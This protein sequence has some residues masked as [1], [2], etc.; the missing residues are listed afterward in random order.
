[1]EANESVVNFGNCDLW[2]PFKDL[3]A[4]IDAALNKK[5]LEALPDLEAA[6]RKHKPNF[7]SLFKN[8]SKNAVS[9]EAVKKSSTEGIRVLGQTGLQILHQSLVDESL[10]ISD[11]VDLNELNA[12][13]LLV[14]GQLQQPHFP[15][16]TRGLVAVLLYYDGRRTLVSSL[17]ALINARRGRTWTYGLNSELTAMITRYTDQLKEENVVTKVIDLIKQIDLPNELHLLQKNRALGGPRYRK[18][19]VDLIQE[20]RQTLADIVF[21]WSCQGQLSNNET[22]YLL[23]YISK[24]SCSADGSLDNVTLTLLISLLNVIDVSVLQTCEDGDEVVQLLHVVADREIIPSLHKE[25]FASERNWQTPK[26][27]TIVQF[28]WAVMLRTLLQFPL[29]SLME[30]FNQFMEQ[31]EKTIDIAIEDNAFESLL[32]LVVAS[33]M[34]HHEEF[35]VKR[36]HTLIT[37]FIVLMPLKVKELRN[38]GDDAARI[39]LAHMQ[40]GIL[41]PPNLSHHLE[42]LM[43]LITHL[44]KDDPLNLELALDYWC[45]TEVPTDQSYSYRPPQR[46]VS[47]YKFIRQSGDMLPAPLFVPYVDMLAGLS[48]SKLCAHH[49]Y[50]L[51]KLNGKNSTGQCSIVSWDHIFASLNR[52]YTSLRVELPPAS[53]Q[54]TYRQHSAMRGITPEEV[55]G[56]ISALRL[57]ETVV[58]NDEMA[59]IS[60]CDVPQYMPLTVL[61]GVVGCSVPPELKAALLKTLSAFALSANIASNLWQSLESFQIIP[62]IKTTSVYQPSGIH[63]ELEEVEARNEEFPITRA[64][65]KLL[66]V[67]FDHPLPS[68]LGSGQRTPGFAPYLEYIIDLVFLRFS[69]RAYRR[70][71]EK[72]EIAKLCL[73][74]FVKLLQDNDIKSDIR[75][76]MLNDMSSSGMMPSVP[77]DYILMTQLLRESGLLRTIMYILD[78][79]SCILSSYM[80]TQGQKQLEMCTLLC[81]ILLQKALIHQPLFLQQVREGNNSIIVSNLDQ[82]LMGIN[83]RHGCADYLVIVAKFVG[84]NAF[85]PKHALAAVRILRHICSNN[86]VA[87]HLA[88]AFATDENESKTLLHGFVECLDTNVLEEI[89]ENKEEKDWSSANFYN[90]ICQELL[91]LLLTCLKHPTPNIAHFLLGFQP[92]HAMSEITLQDP[93]VLGSP[94]TCLHAVLSMLDRGIDLYNYPTCVNEF[95]HVAELAFQLIYV[96]SRNKDTSGPTLRYLRTT[97]DFLYHHLQFLPYKIKKNN[98]KTLACQSWLLKTVATELRVTAAH[99]QR[100]HVQRLLNILLNDSFRSTNGVDIAEAS[101]TPS[102]MFVSVVTSI[103]EPIRRKLMQ[104]LD[105]LEFIQNWPPPPEWEYFDMIEIE[106]LFKAN[107]L[108][109]KDGFSQINVKNIQKQLSEEL[110]SLQGISAV[111]QR[112]VISQEVQSIIHYAKL[113]NNVKEKK[114]IKSQAF[115]AWHLVTEIVLTVCPLDML[116]LEQKHQVILEIAQ[117]LLQRILIDDTL[118]EITASASG[119]MLMLMTTLHHNLNPNIVAAETSSVQVSQMD[120]SNISLPTPAQYTALVI[121]LKRITEC[122]LRTGGGNQRVRINY[123]G[124]LLN[125]LGTVNHSSNTNLMRTQGEVEVLG[126]ESESEKMSREYTEAILEFGE[127]IMEIVCRDACSGH[128]ITKM[129]ALS[130]LDMAIFLDHQ[131]R[132]LNFLIS[133]GYLRHFIDSLLKDDKELQNILTKGSNSL[134]S[135]YVFESKLSLFT[136]IGNSPI[137]AQALLRNG[138]MERLTEC[139][140]L[141]LRPEIYRDFHLKENIEKNTWLLPN[142]FQCYQQIIIPALRVILSMMTSTSPKHLQ[143][144]QQL[145]NFILAHSGIFSDILRDRS[146]LKRLDSLAELSL[147]TAVLSRATLNESSEVPDVTHIETR[148]QI[149]LLRHQLLALLPVLI[150]HNWDSYQF[151]VLLD[152]SVDNVML[153]VKI[154]ELVS[155]VLS[156]CRMVV[157]SSGHGIMSRIL[158]TPN[159]SESLNSEKSH[160][161]DTHMQSVPTS[162]HPPGIGML[163]LLLRQCT[164]QLQVAVNAQKNFQQRIEGLPNL[165]FE[166]MSENLPSGIKTNPFVPHRKEMVYQTLNKLIFLYSQMANILRYIIEVSVYLLWHHLHFFLQTYMGEDLIYSKQ[167]TQ[168]KAIRKLQ[169]VQES[170]KEIPSYI[171]PKSQVTEDWLTQSDVKHLKADIS[172]VMNDYFF[173]ELQ[174]IEQYF[175]EDSK[176]IGFFEA[177]VCRLKRLVQQCT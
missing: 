131:H 153:K 43:Q 105:K 123:Y 1:M 115:E 61:L 107:E 155:N 22:L 37:D 52:Y 19:V 118:P 135:V 177:L 95:P 64:M 4:V 121:I 142:L 165:G 138:I 27:K 50:M 114:Y 72:W 73:Q 151:V 25:L 109:K 80:T 96:L 78:E 13:E 163:I 141:D 8:P 132:W 28:A 93:G 60:L 146:A 175:Q 157:A 33:S 51:L 23:D 69:T 38:R 63:I 89:D 66:N 143:G 158:F 106:R 83:P 108:D 42:H 162:R 48:G 24:Q 77:L 174:S 112:S 98:I 100:S 53:N 56:L 117:E 140:C 103:S 47:L 126:Q 169:A 35:F 84:Y 137:G 149:A 3:Y 67:L 130:L 111:G 154:L 30:E 145:L 94:R 166:K 40:E 87:Q 17:R 99:N 65:L 34:F 148:G 10:I 139:G 101:A 116:E 173:N 171:H 12:L 144:E 81:L 170:T 16:M 59:R 21:G 134:R 31:D 164:L 110:I 20:I 161:S 147:V 36:I 32:H 113:I 6:L 54:Y 97:Y 176:R 26:L 75:N 46:Q 29:P 62:T 172:N 15:G 55:E 41:P 58:S 39:I 104:I 45:P 74:I 2:S 152:D 127:T 156:S 102:S 71:E 159:L 136:R 125:L 124:A 133:R 150:S 85:L 49:C 92:K 57:I 79:G 11:I 128:D 129:L 44:Y 122:L 70:E 14:A 68:A 7:I 90:A 119:V 168:P 88:T 76:S 120:I 9:R 82:L 167:I 91:N 18:Q 160:T 5:D 86:G